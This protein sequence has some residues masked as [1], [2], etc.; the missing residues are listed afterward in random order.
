[1]LSFY[2]VNYLMGQKHQQF[3]CW[4][5]KK[6]AESLNLSCFKITMQIYCYYFFTAKIK[7]H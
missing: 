5:S 2:L 7:T 3:K 4:A 6:I 1:M